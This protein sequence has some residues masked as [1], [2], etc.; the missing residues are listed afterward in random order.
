MKLIS[1]LSLLPISLLAQQVSTTSLAVEN[2]LILKSELH[3]NSRVKSIPFKNIGP[4]IMSG[5]VVDVDVNPTNPNEFYVAYASGG[6][7]YT[8]S[9]GTNFEPILDKAQ[10][11]NIGDIAVD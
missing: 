7:W 4:T 2:A 10:T 8:N 9:N 1:F 11:Q 5:R 6:L 3:N